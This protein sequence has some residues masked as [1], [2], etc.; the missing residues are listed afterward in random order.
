MATVL[1]PQQPGAAAAAGLVLRSKFD[2]TAYASDDWST[3]AGTRSLTP[4]AGTVVTAVTFTLA[5]QA[6]PTSWDLVSGTGLKWV[7]GTGG[8]WY[9]TSLPNSGAAYARADISDLIGS[10]PAEDTQ[11]T[12]VVQW[13]GD[14]PNGNYEQR[15]LGLSNGTASFNAQDVSSGGSR[16]ASL[17]RLLPTTTFVDKTGVTFDWVAVEIKGSSAQAKYGTGAFDWSGGTLIGEG[18]IDTT[19]APRSAPV[20]SLGAAYA[21]L[22]AAGSGSSFDPVATSLECYELVR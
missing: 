9:G 8:D 1:H 7:T 22:Y 16:I 17:K 2:F 15:G 12:L 11:V 5:N 3:G 10:T 20:F 13:G 6:S 18:S 19:G 14:V 4:T 21:L